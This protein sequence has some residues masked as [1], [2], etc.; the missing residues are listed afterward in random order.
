MTESISL[1]KK[2]KGFLERILPGFVFAL[3]LAQPVLDVISYWANKWEFTSVTT[4]ARFAMFAAVMLY[5]FIISDKKRYYIIAGVLISAYWMLHVVGCLKSAGGYASPF[6]DLSNFLRT[7]QMPLVTVAFITCF[8]KSDEVPVYVQRAFLINLVVML[9][10]TALSY[11]TASQIY[12]YGIF[13]KG[14]MGWVVSQNAQSAI[15]AAITPLIL[16][17]AYKKRNIMWF[18]GVAV[19]TFANLFFVGTRVDYFTIPI[20]AA[21]MIIMMLISREKKAGYYI[22]MA[23]LAMLC[24][25]CYKYSIVNDNIENHS[26]A[27]SVKQDEFV[28]EIQNDAPQ[29]KPLPKNIDWDTYY[30]LDVKTRK[31][32]YDL[33][34]RYTGAMVGRFGFER[35]FEKYN[36]SLDVSELTAQRQQ[37]RYFAEMVWEDSSNFERLFG[38]EYSELISTFEVADR[39]GT[40]RNVTQVFDLENDFPAVFFYSGYI[41]FAAFAVFIAYFALLMAVAVITRF[42]KIMTVES[43]MVGVSFF[44]MMGTAGFAGYVFRRPNSSIFLS[45]ILAYIYYLTVVR[46][47]V[48]LTDIF[49]IF[50]KNKNF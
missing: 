46:E 50:S 34:K 5:A 36:Y 6:S 19:V 49:R 44:L 41:G 18:Y 48:R 14:L 3:L 43:G 35:V 42:K 32:I 29:A 10:V 8:K 17:Y 27:I 45:V 1:Y 24:L 7:I 9:H 11:M 40:V 21:A 30:S 47:N 4:L 13:Q 33:Y 23:A 22:V 28:D 38:Y 39:N 12:T 26:Y 31:S 37:K 25:I 20:V 16:L 15:L 2:T